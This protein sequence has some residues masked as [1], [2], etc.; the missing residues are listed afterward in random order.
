MSDKKDLESEL[1]N[2][3]YNGQVQNVLALLEKG[4]DVDCGRVSDPPLLHAA[5]MG[6]LETVK[7]LLEHGADVRFISEKG[8]TALSY[9]Q[10]RGHG[11]IV[12]FLQKY[13]QECSKDQILF[14][15]TLGGRVL[16]EIFDFTTQERFSLI[17][18]GEGGAAEAMLREPFSAVE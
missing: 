10:T 1:R 4:V 5:Y 16:E 9:G 3:A 8:N 15:R 17:C 13:I 11:A 2:A 14:R 18:K 6:Q 12:D 7:I